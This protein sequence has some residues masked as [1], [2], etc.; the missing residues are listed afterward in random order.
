M[1]NQANLNNK[2]KHEQVKGKKHKAVHLQQ[3]SGFHNTTSIPQVLTI[4]ILVMVVILLATSP[5]CI[6]YYG[7][8]RQN[9]GFGCCFITEGP[10]VELGHNPLQLTEKLQA[11]EQYSKNI[12]PEE[13]LNTKDKESKKFE[14]NQ[15]NSGKANPKTGKDGKKI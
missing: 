14:E 13:T 15:N 5:T 10:D 3:D 7:R 2:S 8:K 9:D 6:W 4:I 11:I 1:V 12:D